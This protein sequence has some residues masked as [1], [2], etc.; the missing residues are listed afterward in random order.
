MHQRASGQAV[1][2]TDRSDLARVIASSSVV[3][4]CLGAG[5]TDVLSYLTLGQ[6][7]TSAMT[8]CAALFFLKLAGGQYPTALRAAIALPSYMVGCAL[9]TALQPTDPEAAKSP[10]TLRRLLIAECLILGLYCVLAGLG[11]HPP[12]GW[13][14]DALIFLSAT[15]MGVQSIVARDLREPGISTVVLNP[16]MT[17]LG[18]ALTKLSLGREPK[19]PRQNRLQIFV[20]LSYAAG[21]TITAL[22]IALH[23]HLTDLLPLI[24]AMLVLALQHSICV[25]TTNS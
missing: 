25:R 11:R 19:L 20:L 4:L 16:T 10:F 3:L 8:G 5:A 7:F 24:I 2:E 9:A 13:S 17:S 22:G 21:A 6:I 14:R 18:V 15:A 12:T 1:G 23:I